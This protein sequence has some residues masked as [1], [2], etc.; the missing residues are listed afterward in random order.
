MAGQ[1]NE[2]CW[3]VRDEACRAQRDEDRQ[4]KT[5]AARSDGKRILIAIKSCH[6]YAHRAQAQRETWIPEVGEA[7]DV[8]FFL[9]EK[10][11]YSPRPDEI[12]L[13]VSDT[14]S[15]LPAKTRGIC[16][17][18]A[19]R[20]YDFVFTCD[21]D[22]YVQPD[23]LLRSGFEQHDYV[24]RFRGPSGGYAAP[25]CS[26]FAYWL[27]RRALEIVAAQQLG[28]DT[29]DD[30]WIGNVLLEAG[31]SGALD[32]RYRVTKCDESL[33]P[34]YKGAREDEMVGNAL[35]C[36]GLTGRADHRYAIVASPSGANTLSG[37]EGPLDGNDI[38]A[39]CEFEPE[40]MHKVHRQWTWGEKAKPAPQLPI[41][42]LS[43][44]EVLIKTFLR[45][46]YLTRCVAGIQKS[47]PDVKMVI[48]DDG[49][50]SRDKL[51]M[52]AKLRRLGHIYHWLPK[53]SG[54]GAKANAAI[55]FYDRT[56]VLIGSDDFDFGD[57]TV[58]RGIERLV[59]VLDNV[60]EIAV[61]SGRVANRPYE[62]TLELGDDW[63]KET[64][65]YRGG[66]RVKG[67]D[68]RLCDLTVNYS[69][70]RREVFEKVGWDSD[71]K[72]GGGEHGAFF[73]DLK[74]AG[75]QVA[76]VNGVSI[77]ELPANASWRHPSYLT[78]RGRA[79]SPERPC[80][81]RRGIEHYLTSGGCEMC[82]SNCKR[83][84][85]LSC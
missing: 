36:R 7:A 33:V 64:N 83:L 21:D 19:E 16:R 10:D 74:R 78:M 69:L 82:G 84:A 9:G 85:D 44:V 58:R 11:V 66:A 23:R 6:K 4:K 75:Y 13:P 15:A 52:A 35:A 73:I 42:S 3:T 47:L 39:A 40:A 53:D 68:Y 30:R 80:Y 1:R 26:G 25:Y 46:G 8:F 43:R 79:H 48:V 17:W 55:Q 24:G 32:E 70:I 63:A 27:S 22:T 31:I 5:L 12:V 37:T 67:I 59:A 28:Q 34:G 61:A 18:A 71:V 54:F 72:I 57:P 56:Y 76:W 38:I 41:G 65:G 50:E 14:Y 60:P 45:D 77:S 20:R 49:E 62:K 51:M 2:T 29:A 81:L